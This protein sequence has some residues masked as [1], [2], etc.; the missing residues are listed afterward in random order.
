M[1]CILFYRLSEGHTDQR[2]FL[3]VRALARSCGNS[4]F[5]RRLC[6]QGQPS[7]QVCLF[8]HSGCAAL[9]FRCSAVGIKS[10]TSIDLGVPLARETA[11]Y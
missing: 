4:G 1:V 7:R 6:C 5:T 2:E 8:L 10:E 3:Q 11:L 9:F